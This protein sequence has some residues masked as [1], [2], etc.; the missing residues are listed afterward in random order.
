MNP[1]NLLFLVI[2]LA[3]CLTQVAADIYA[4]SLP[5]IADSL[6]APIHLVQWSM[7]IYMLGVALSQL[8]YGPLSE[9]IGRKGPILIG[10]GIMIIGSGMC[11]LANN[12][13]LLI[14]GR[15]VQGCGAGACAALWRSIFRDV[16][17]GEELAKYGSYLVVFVMFIV[18]A[19]P[20]LGGYL[21]EYFG[22]RASF[23]FMCFYTVIA[24]LSILYGFKETSTHHHPERLKL[25]YVTSTFYQLLKSPIFMGVTLCTFLSYGA[26]FS[27]FTAGPVLLIDR[28]GL[29][30]V[31]FGWI[32]LLGGGS[33]YALAGWLNGKWVTRLGMS[34]MMRIGFS[35]MFV[36]G[37]MMLLG[38]LIFGVTATVI[39]APILLFYFGS[40]FIWPNAFAIAFTPFG[41][42][43]GYAGALYGFMQTGSRID[44]RDERRVMCIYGNPEVSDRELIL[45][46]VNIVDKSSIQSHSEWQA[47]GDDYF[48]CTRSNP[49]ECPYG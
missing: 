36:S 33:A 3:V 6:S 25:S 26:F 38:K 42:I 5:A 24:L 30:P 34:N 4:P 14:A 16:F 47:F 10:L 28:A 18:P 23:V 8:I 13:D 29:T 9:G 21:Q 31:E 40:T 20:A 11:L 7:A 2:I 46:T 27:W 22:W 15:F 1:N 44:P 39:V 32:T 37:I 35:I 43:A 19:A 48:K 49:E 12:I 17:S 41:K 45:E